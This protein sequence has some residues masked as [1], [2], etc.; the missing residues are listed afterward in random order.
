MFCAAGLGHD[1]ISLGWELN[2][3]TRFLL[4]RA[5]SNSFAHCIG[6]VISLAD[7]SFVNKIL[8]WEQRAT[9]CCNGKRYLRQM[10]P[11]GSVESQYAHAPCI[12]LQMLYEES[13]TMRHKSCSAPK[14]CQ[15]NDDVYGACRC[16]ATQPGKAK[17]CTHMLHQVYN[18]CS[19]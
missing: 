8:Q 18:G 5:Y 10:Q 9:P 15:K 3:C 13:S 17:Y 11:W 2:F 19:S 6:S 1:A 7:N 14:R 4:C 16:T 12:Q